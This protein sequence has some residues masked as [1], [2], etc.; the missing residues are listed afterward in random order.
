MKNEICGNWYNFF[1][2]VTLCIKR[3]TVA[4]MGTDVLV[5]GPLG[6]RYPACTPLVVTKSGQYFPQ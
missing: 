1:Q 2:N 4:P 5:K 3:Y 6:A